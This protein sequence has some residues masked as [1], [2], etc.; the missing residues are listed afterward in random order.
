MEAGSSFAVGFFVCS[1]GSQFCGHDVP[2][3]A[4]LLQDRTLRG[5]MLARDQSAH[6]IAYLRRLRLWACRL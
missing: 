2:L 3:R 5:R 6:Q 1:M 4:A